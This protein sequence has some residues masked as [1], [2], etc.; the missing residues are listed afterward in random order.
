MDTFLRLLCGILCIGGGALVHSIDV[1]GGV[2]EVLYS[3]LIWSQHWVDTFHRLAPKTSQTL[4]DID[5][6][7]DG[8]NNVDDKRAKID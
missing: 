8:H 4:P 7:E 5:D 6:E 2:D 1:D 3:A